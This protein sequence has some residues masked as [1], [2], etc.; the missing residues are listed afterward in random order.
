MLLRGQHWKI[1]QEDKCI[2]Q[3]KNFKSY[4]NKE[5]AKV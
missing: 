4:E 2:V 5:E 1:T 3:I